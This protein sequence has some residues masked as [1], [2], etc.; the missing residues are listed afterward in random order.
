M[1]LSQA[2]LHLFF[3]SIPALGV[4]LGTVMSYSARRVLPDM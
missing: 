1:L 4:I 3:D 2:P